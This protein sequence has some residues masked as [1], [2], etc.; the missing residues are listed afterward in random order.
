MVSRRWV[1]RRGSA[2][3]KRFSL[4]PASGLRGTIVTQARPGASSSAGEGWPS[5]AHASTEHSAGKFP[6]K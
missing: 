4:S 6:V 3:V 2:T 5:A 1:N